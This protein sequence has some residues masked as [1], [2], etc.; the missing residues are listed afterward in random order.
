MYNMVGNVF[1]LIPFDKR[2]PVELWSLALGH[3]PQMG[4]PHSVL[5]L[6]PYTATFI[7]CFLEELAASVH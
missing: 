5:T 3:D 2:Y 1:L 7:C 4:T 6:S